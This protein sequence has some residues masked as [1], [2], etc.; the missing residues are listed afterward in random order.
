MVDQEARRRID[1]LETQGAQRDREIGDLS[2][3]LSRLA[4]TLET[5]RVEAAGAR[6][7]AGGPP[8]P[9]PAVSP[10]VANRSPATTPTSPPYVALRRPPA[11]FTSRIAVDFPALFTEFRGKRFT[12]LWRGSRHGFGA[13]EFHVRCDGHAN[14][15]LLIE[16]TAG[17]IFGGFTPVEWESRQWNGK[18]GSENN[19]YKADPSL[20]SF[21]FTLANP[22]GVPARTFALKAEKKDQ[23]IECDASW[24]P[25]FCDIVVID[26]CNANSRSYTSNFGLSYANDTGLYGGTFLTGSDKFTVKEIEV[27]EITD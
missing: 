9:K 26:N 27:F 2:R 12:R 16:D 6:S 3:R 18:R 17:N 1:A 10:A 21:I 15:L 11:G 7:P 5:V 24:G 19:C 4:A 25:H 23:A 14:T 20:K 22:Q 8:P 13:R